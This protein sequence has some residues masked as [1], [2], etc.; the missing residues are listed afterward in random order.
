M[1]NW[2]ALIGRI[3]VAYLFIPAGIGK[4]TGFAGTVG[5]IA[6]KGLPMPTV[7]AGIAVVVELLVAAA[8]LLGYKTRC[9]AAVLAVFTVAAGVLFHDYWTLPAA[10][11]MVQ[12]LLFTKNIAVAGGLLAFVA[13]G[14]GAFSLDARRGSAATGL[15]VA[16]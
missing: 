14:A 6:S 16:A 7:A 2:T 1:Q 9:A 3:L 11:Q 4:L 10:Q 8:F 5:Y 13:F 12:Q 15:P